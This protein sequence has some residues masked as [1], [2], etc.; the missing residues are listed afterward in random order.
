[1][2]FFKEINGIFSYFC[3]KDFSSSRKYAR[4]VLVSPQLYAADLIDKNDGRDEG[5]RLLGWGLNP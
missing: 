2:I 4:K 3:G 5:V 1:M